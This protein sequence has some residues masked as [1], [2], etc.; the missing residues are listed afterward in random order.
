MRPIPAALVILVLCL[1]SPAPVF[2][3]SSQASLSTSVPRLINVSG[4]YRPADKQPLTPLEQVTFA[5]YAQET[6]GTP[7]WQET[8][9]VAVDADGR[10][11]VLLG[12]TQPDGVPL[13]V[14]ASG[15]AQWLGITFHRP[16]DVEGP[17]MRIT[18]VPYALHAADAVTLGGRPASDY[19]LTPTKNG[20]TTTSAAS[21]TATADPTVNPLNV[22]LTGT[23][24]A[25][26]KYV[27]ADD[28]GPSA[29]SEASGRLGI[30]TGAALP[31]DYLHIRFND[32][33]GAFTGLAVQNLSNN[34]NAASGMLFYDHNGALTQFQGFNNTNHGY[35]INNIA[36]NGANQFDGSYSFLIGSTPR[37]NVASNGNIGIGTTTPSA[38]LEVSN[39]VP[40]GP[41]NMWMTSYTNAV[42][43]YYLARRAR[44]TPG[45][46]AAVQNGDGLAGFYGDGYGTTAFGG[47]FAGG[48]TVQA[49]QNWTGHGA[50]HRARVR[51]HCVQ[52]DCHGDP[53]DPRRGR[54]LR[55]RHVPSDSTPRNQQRIDT[56]KSRE[57]NDRHLQRGSG[58]LFLTGR[59]AR[60]TPAAPTAVQ[61]GDG[62]LSLSGRGYGT[63]QFGVG[64]GAT[65][66]MRATENYTNTAMGGLIQFFTT[67][68]GTTTLT[69]RMTIDQNGF[70]G[71]GTTP[72]GMLDIARDGTTNLTGTSYGGQGTGFKAR[73]SRGTLAAPT[74]TQSG[75]ELAEFTAAG[76]GTTGFNETAGWAAFAAEN[77]T[78]AAQGTF[79]GFATTPVGSNEA[80]FNLAIL[81]NG[82][83]G[84]GTPEDVNGFPTA[85]DQAS[86]LWRHSRRHVWHQRLPA[87]LRGH[88]TYWLLLVR[89]TLEEEHHAVRTD[90][91]QGDGAP[92]G[93]LLLAER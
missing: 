71:I 74:A 36:K 20:L 84:V 92:A 81:P 55:D 48:M 21:T 59:K 23:P 68:N 73:A 45:A 26:A 70:V 39:A 1:A 3:Q 44:G 62:L 78:D 29:V 91:R 60:G 30:N 75:D 77:W 9:Q 37:F 63:T 12:A 6:G 11:A 43:P 5:V 47:G 33:F 16:G 15:E 42:N 38:L 87:E 72:T 22:V 53:D 2:A 83:I 41:A 19:V 31:F 10:Y 58:R 88:W 40:G 28:V 56:S 80:Q 89:P 54:E 34:A 66:G 79:M 64:G 46:P 85:T 4:V 67:P 14:F 65:I 90:A 35:V 50:R 8:Q 49:V 93:A 18:S 57:R 13:D 82:N 61:N 52:Y 25:L 32:P 27:N 51:D 86:S 17:R 7:V 24:N 69:Q 76:Y